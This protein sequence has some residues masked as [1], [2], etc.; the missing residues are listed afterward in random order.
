MYKLYACSKYQ[1]K[2]SYLNLKLGQNKIKLSNIKL[3]LSVQCHLVPVS[4]VQHRHIKRQLKHLEEEIR[5]AKKVGQLQNRL[6]HISTRPR[7]I[8]IYSKARGI[9]VKY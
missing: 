3:D 7:I 4:S 8:K 1:G 2:R 6:S 5:S 9:L